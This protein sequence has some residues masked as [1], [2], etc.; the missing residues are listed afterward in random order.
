MKL[1]LVSGLQITGGSGRSFT[2]DRF[3]ISIT[4]FHSVCLIGFKILILDT[5]WFFVS[6]NFVMTSLLVAE[7]PILKGRRKKRLWRLCMTTETDPVIA[8]PEYSP[9][10]ERIEV[11]HCVSSRGDIASCTP[12]FGKG[13][14][15]VS[16]VDCYWNG[17]GKLGK[18]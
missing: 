16:M 6:R 2:V 15:E 12:M 13:V 3:T 1:G 7:A 5:S 18:Q 8:F 4:V 10:S 11:A 14:V 17:L 9:F